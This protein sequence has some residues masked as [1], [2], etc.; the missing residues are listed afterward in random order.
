MN[1]VH[2]KIAA[3]SFKGR[4]IRQAEVKRRS[5]DKK[6]QTWYASNKPAQK[7]REIERSG[8]RIRRERRK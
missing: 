6:T 7:D 1:K 8:E 4:R 5:L 2:K 3:K